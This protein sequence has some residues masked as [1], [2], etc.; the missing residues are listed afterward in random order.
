M[1]FLL[2]HISIWS[3]SIPFYM[4]AYYTTPQIESMFM[5][6][7]KWPSK[8]AWSF[9]FSNKKSHFIVFDWY[10]DPSSPTINKDRLK[11][12]METKASTLKWE[13]WTLVLFYSRNW[14]C[15]TQSFRM[16]NFFAFYHHH[17]IRS[18][19]LIWF[20]F[21]WEWM[22]QFCLLFSKV[23]QKIHNE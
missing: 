6:H 19:F 17:R 7:F 1:P 18:L 9:S 22:S 8:F 16:T 2:L 15:K 5:T 10:F 11:N 23:I 21:Y 20:H 14:Q 12:W 13:H 4:S 3:G